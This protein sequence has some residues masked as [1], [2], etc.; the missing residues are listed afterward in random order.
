MR[1]DKCVI[2]YM[3]R[4]VVYLCSSTFLRRIS[5]MKNLALGL[6][7]VAA[8]FSVACGGSDPA[9]D[10]QQTQAAPESKTVNMFGYKFNPNTLTIPAGTTVVF[11]N[12]DPE[13]HNVNIAALNLD[14][15]VE[16]GQSF[17]YT[18]TTSGEFAVTNRLVSNPMTATI[19]VQ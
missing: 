15:I 6:I 17:S 5:M 12:K 11:N 8:T 7:L 2:C 10:D 3:L 19:I 4:P 18:F 13:N 16:P 9:P 14:E 1:V